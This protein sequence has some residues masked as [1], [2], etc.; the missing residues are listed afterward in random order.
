MMWLKVDVGLSRI[1]RR[2][3]A[4]PTPR[5]PALDGLC[6]WLC[7]VPRRPRTGFIPYG[8]YLVGEFVMAVPPLLL[9]LLYAKNITARF[10]FFS[11]E[12]WRQLKWMISNGAVLHGLS[13]SNSEMK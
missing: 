10:A 9:E 7:Q 8:P 1:L 2:R 11:K 3:T 4:L 5:A 6:R 13:V 12:M